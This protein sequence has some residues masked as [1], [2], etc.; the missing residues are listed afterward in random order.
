[1]RSG[2]VVAGRRPVAELLRARRRPARRL[3]VGAG[4]TLP[5]EIVALARSAGV[6]VEFV[7]AEALTELCGIDSHQGVVAETV[8]LESTHPDDVMHDASLVVALDGVVDPRNLGAV[9]RV[10]EAAG[11]DG[12]LVQDRN[13][14]PL[15]AAAQKA[16]AG[17]AEWL[18][19]SSV[20]NLSVALERAKDSG[21][22]VVGLESGAPTLKESALFEENIVVVAGSEGRGLRRRVR[23]TCDALVGIPTSGNVASLNVST[24]VAVAVFEASTRHRRHS[25]RTP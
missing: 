16:A 19:V 22:W 15:S 11:G 1:M 5:D 8:P 12:V 25:G 6:P 4:A 17:A 9:I 21:L 7:D 2:A 24:A 20:V 10:V 23:D 13:R 3:W 14:A 18:P